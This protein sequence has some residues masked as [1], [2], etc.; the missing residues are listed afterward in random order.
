[1][2][3]NGSPKSNGTP[4]YEPELDGCEDQGH[5]HRPRSLHQEDTITSEGKR[6]VCHKPAGWGTKHVGMGPCRL[7]GGNLPGVAA[8]AVRDLATQPAKMLGTPVDIGPSEAL[9]KELSETAGI[10]AWLRGMVQ[11]LESNDDLVWGMVEEVVEPTIRDTDGQTIIRETSGKYRAQA[12]IW[13]TLLMQERQHLVRVCEAA[14]K[15]G[16]SERIVQAYENV[17]GQVAEVYMGMFERVLLR[18]GL[19]PEQKALVP[20]AVVA[21]VQAIQGDIF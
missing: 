15:A 16:V 8:K 19:T 17:H 6:R 18:L 14:I 4:D 9:L 21:E 20:S 1:M 11:Q 7:H 12:S 2:N 5:C 10:V 3:D 13:Y